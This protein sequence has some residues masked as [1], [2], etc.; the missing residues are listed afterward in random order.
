M[1]LLENEE[2]LVCERPFIC[3]CVKKKQ[4]RE[5]DKLKDMRKKGKGMV[6]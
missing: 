2:S 1:A 6:L 4:E 5:K 3:P